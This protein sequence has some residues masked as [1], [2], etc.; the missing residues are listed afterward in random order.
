MKKIYLE[1]A[2][3]PNR[4]NRLNNLALFTE[5]RKMKDKDSWTNFCTHLE[6]LNFNKTFREIFVKNRYELE[7]SNIKVG[8]THFS[9]KSVFW[10]KVIFEQKCK[11]PSESSDAQWVGEKIYVKILKASAWSDWV[12]QHPK[13][14][15]VTRKYSHP[16]KKFINLKLIRS[17]IFSWMWIRSAWWRLSN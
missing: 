15:K 7:F 4:V 6:T 12:R 17:F 9:R 16:K 8:R 5:S 3:W 10:E 14:R 1:F 11:D 13:A 2:I